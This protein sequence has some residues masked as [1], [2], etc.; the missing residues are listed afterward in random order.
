MEEVKNF[1]IPSKLSGQRIDKALALLDT[2]FSRG[3]FQELIKENLV[4]VNSKAVNASYKVTSGDEI[5]VKAGK[6]FNIKV[7]KI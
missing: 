6:T 4:L 1:I 2:N 5:E 3:Y 7:L